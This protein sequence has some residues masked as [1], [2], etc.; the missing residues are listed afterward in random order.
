MCISIYL[1]IFIIFLSK[2][3]YESFHQFS[4][5]HSIRKQQIFISLIIPQYNPKIELDY[6]MFPLLF[7][8]ITGKKCFSSWRKTGKIRYSRE[9]LLTLIWVK[10]QLKVVNNKMISNCFHE[11]FNVQLLPNRMLN[12]RNGMD[13]KYLFKSELQSP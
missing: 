2:R 1:S 5:K 6:F 13:I 4:S 10:I 12:E 3:L 11:T 7:S 8:N 9:I